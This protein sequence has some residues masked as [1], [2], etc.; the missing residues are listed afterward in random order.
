MARP[1]RGTSGTAAM[2][3]RFR[4]QAAACGRLG[5]PM[6]AELLDR[7]ADDL[8]AGGVSTAVLAGHEHDPGPS[9]LA[10]RL[11]GS[12]HR[13]VLEGRAAELAAFYPSVGGAWDLDEGWPAF[14]AVLRDMPDQVREWLDRPPQ[15]NEVGRAVALM[16]GLL[17]IGESHRLPVRLLEIGSSGGLNLRADAFAYSGVDGTRQGPADS[18]LHLGDVWEGAPLTPWPGLEVVERTGSDVMP[19]DVTSAEGRLKLTSY[20]WPDQTVR[21]ERLRRACDVATEVPVEVRP[22]DAVSFVQ[23]I[24]LVEGTTTVLWHS[25]M[26]QYLSPDDRSAVTAHV[27][28]LGAAARETS[29]F[30]HLLLEPARRTPASDHEFLVVLRLWPTGERRVLGSSTPHGIPTIWE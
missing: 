22:Q 18:P 2:V 13:L 9:A 17:R 24:E 6:Y 20:V 15:T 11:T 27:E 26:W 28:A 14:E 5:S 7:V 1:D 30:A 23:G 25:V 3:R 4:E 29:P 16:G 19:V 12:V 10:L 8:A 21:L